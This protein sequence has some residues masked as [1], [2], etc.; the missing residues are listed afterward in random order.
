LKFIHLIILICSLFLSKFVFAQTIAVV[1]IQSLIDSNTYYKE[2]MKDIEINQ[3]KYLEKFELKEKELSKKLKDI[4][5]SK[6]IL[7]EIEI[8]A[9]IDNY[10]EE[11]KAFTFEVEEFNQH[12]QDQVI[13]IKEIILKEIFILLEKYAIENKVD[14]ILDSANY[15]IASN[16]IDVTDIIKNKLQNINLKLEYT[17]FEKN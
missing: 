9:Q 15:L 3:E 14:L 12:Y 7:N 16:S 6:L 5:Q 1:N 4:E 10:N 8:N 2:I 11:L 13:N 17:N